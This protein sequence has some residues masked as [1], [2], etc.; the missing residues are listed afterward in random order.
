MTK[1]ER[2]MDRIRV[3]V[4]NENV[5]E[6]RKPEILEHY[7]DG[8]HGA[9]ASVFGDERDM[10][11]SAATMDQAECGLTEEVLDQTDV[12]VWWSHHRFEDVPQDIVDRVKE[13]V[14]AGMGLIVLHSAHFARVFQQLMGTSCNL[15]WR[16]VGESERLWVVSPGHP[17]V[18]GI[19]D[20]IDL[21]HEEMYGEPFDI[22]APDEL[23]FIS[24]FKGG[25][26]FRS[27]CCYVRGKGRIFYFRPGHETYPTYLNAKIQQVLRNAARWAASAVSGERRF[28][29]QDPLEPL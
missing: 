8:I 7:P 23:V 18:K 11:V 20:Y 16:N 15:K 1:G 24:W 5:E 27:G 9:L 21:P 26:V 4:W 19:D 12:V 3:L 22:P 6:M 29:Q 13:R 2:I 28:G 25:E 14:L 17:I 10:V